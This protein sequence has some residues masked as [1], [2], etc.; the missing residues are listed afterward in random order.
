[1][2]RVRYLREAEGRPS[3]IKA[4]AG[5]TGYEKLAER[6]RRDSYFDPDENRELVDSKYESDLHDS[7]DGKDC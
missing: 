2:G 1:M 5:R 7:Y 6:G 3:G 4:S